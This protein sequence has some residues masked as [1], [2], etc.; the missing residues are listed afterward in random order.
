LEALS[1]CLLQVRFMKREKNL[2]LISGFTDLTLSLLQL[3]S[4]ATL[5]FI[6]KLVSGRSNDNKIC[7]YNLKQ[8]IS[9]AN[10]AFKA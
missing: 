4:S 3:V 6:K 9:A 2:S 5:T 8:I 7:V 1:L 10:P